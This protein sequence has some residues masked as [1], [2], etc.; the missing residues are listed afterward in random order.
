MPSPLDVPNI[1]GINPKDGS[2]MERRSA[3]DEPMSA[4]AFKIMNDPFVGTLT[5]IRIYS[6]VLETGT[7]ALS[8]SKGKK[9]RIGR[10]MEMHANSRE[11]IKA[12]RADYIVA[13]AGHKDVITGDTLCD[14]KAPIVLERMEFPDP[15]IKVL[16]GAA[17]CTASA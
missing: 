12:A 9:E 7:Y 3:D 10:L 17:C 6:G 13:V 14:E 1:K 2:D 15:V 4:L 5:F 8:A 16:P 11:D